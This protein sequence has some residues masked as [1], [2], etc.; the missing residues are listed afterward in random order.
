MS[1]SPGQRDKAPGRCVHCGADLP[2]GATECPT[3]ATRPVPARP[4]PAFPS[5]PGYKIVRVLGEGGMGL[6]YEAEEVALGRRVALK[7]LSKRF[8]DEQEGAY[9]RFQR[10]ARNMA[11]VEHPHIVRIYAYG[12]FEGSPYI[13]MELIEGESLAGAIRRSGRLPVTEALRILGQIVDALEA[14]WEKGIIHRDIK[15]SNVMLDKKNQVRVAD[16]GLAKSLRQGTDMSLTQTGLVMGSPHYISPE[17][18]SGVPVD[19]RCD[20]YSLGIVLFEMLTGTPP[21]EGNTPFAVMSRHLKDPLPKLSEKIPDAP[22]RLQLLVDWL[23]Q[24][25]PQARPSSYAELRKKLERFHEEKWPAPPAGEAGGEETAALPVPQKPR[26]LRVAAIG[27]AALLVVVAAILFWTQRGRYSARPAG[28]EA[29]GQA[30]SAGGVTAPG[31]GIEEAGTNANGREEFRNGIDGALMVLVPQGAYSIGSNDRE[32][33]ASEAPLHTVTLDAFLI[34]KF[35]VTAAQYRRFCEATGRDF[36]AQ[37]PWSREAHPIVNVDWDDAGAYCKWAGGRLP[38]E[39]EWEAAARGGAV[40]AV[41]PWGDDFRCAMGN[42]DDETGHTPYTVPG[43]PGCDNIAETAPVGRFPANGYGLYDM[44]GNV[45]EWCS[46]WFG[47]AYYRQG[48]AANPAGPPSGEYHV[49]RGGAWVNPLPYY[50]RASSRN[51]Y[52][53]D[54]RSDFVGFRCAAAK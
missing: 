7:V 5:I 15:P 26:S 48:P 27:A 11:S 53:P 41:Y 47:E 51:W 16:F 8:V 12:E 40:N 19:F 39:A 31:A 38:T 32:A 34:D 25:D 42:F 9:A 18:L 21:F 36:P 49:V 43:G 10:E 29:G 33:D 2:P 44:A 24:K 35:E 13:A 46:D 28:G 6:V 22:A 23:T 37:P 54:F 14:A 50:F 4:K 20:I 1:S 30:E 52:E 3:C 17:Q 45:W